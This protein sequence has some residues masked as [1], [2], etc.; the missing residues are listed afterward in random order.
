MNYEITDLGIKDYPQSVVENITCMKSK[1]GRVN[2]CESCINTQVT[3]IINEY[4]YMNNMF[5]YF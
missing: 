3:T 1:Q 5:I 4:I 2:K